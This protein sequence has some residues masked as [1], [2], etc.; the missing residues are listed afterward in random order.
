MHRY[1]NKF[2]PTINIT[3]MKRHLFSTLTA[4]LVLAL[5]ACHTKPSQPAAEPESL[6]PLPILFGDP[7]VLLASDGNYYMYGTSLADGFEAYVSADLHD[8]QPCGQVFRAGSSD[9]WDIDCFWAPEV[10]E[11]NGKFYLFYSANSKDNPT[12]EAENFQIGVA[13]ADSPKGPFTHL[14][15]R[16]VFKASYPVID[17][18]V[19]FD[20]SS[21]RCWLYFSRCC[22]KHPVESEIADSARRAGTFAQVEESWVYGVE[23]KPDFSGIIGEPVLL[24]APPAQLSDTQAEWES[25]SVLSGEV[26]RRW[27][28]GSFIFKNNDTYYM[29]Y[30]A[31]SYQGA[32]YAVGYATSKHPLG[33]FVKSEFNPILQENI[34]RGGSVMGTG[35]NMMF[36]TTDGQMMTSYHGRL[37]SNP[38]ERVVFI[39]PMEIDAEGHLIIHGPTVKQEKKDSADTED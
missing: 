1:Q 29:M 19:L 38:G 32:H 13:V 5:S 22:Y 25:R 9:D 7:Y 35:H 30:S 14:M 37:A 2:N 11:R 39:D 10:Y 16:P 31:N 18:N 26:N 28:E 24:L 34:S 12:A 8:W 33:P 4:V 36:R 23:L 6:N 15:N 27:T 17:A 3:S 21:D 20:D